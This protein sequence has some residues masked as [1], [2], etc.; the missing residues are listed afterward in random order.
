MS[1]WKI[2]VAPDCAEH[3]PFIGQL[4]GLLAEGQGQVVYDKRNRVVSFDN[5]G[6][7]LMVKCFKRVNAIQSIAYTCWRQ[8]KA[9]RAYLYAGEF[10]RRGI[11][12]PQ[13]IAYLEQYSCGLFTT[14]YFVSQAVEGTET[15]L[16]L[17]EVKDYDPRLADAVAK[18]VVDMHSK[19]ILHGDLNLSNFLCTER[20]GHYHFA[21]IDTN[22]SRFCDGWPTYE[23][24]LQNLVRTTHRRDLYEYLVGSYARQRGWD[25]QLAVSHALGLLDKFENRRFR[26]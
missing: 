20:D 22:R 23:E 17:R 10:R 25:V 26:L 18:Q 6:Q 11:D 12:T 7:T 15:H 24:C 13:P 5:M 16:L 21:M 4:P 19:G 9:E 2:V 8:S 1:R 14:G 3:Q